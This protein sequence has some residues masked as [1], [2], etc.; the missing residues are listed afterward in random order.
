[1]ENSFIEIF[2]KFGHLSFTEMAKLYKISRFKTYQPG[3]IIVKA[4]DI[5]P[6]S[7]AV[8][9]GVVRT[10]M[11]KTSGEEVTVRI[12]AEKQMTG[13]ANCVLNNEPSFEYL[14]AVEKCSVIE[15]NLVKLK[16]YAKENIRILHFYNDSIAEALNEAVHRI[17]FF[18]SKSPE[19]RYRDL[20]DETPDIIRRVPQK[21]L[22][23][24]IGVT[25]VSLSRIRSRVAKSG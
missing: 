20:L 23:S 1:M 3:E 7:I 19:E 8:L 5:H 4:G 12:V 10:Y 11:I 22:A 6:Y 25:T 14:E 16:D 21:Y 13:A 24:Y 17:S 18:A 2:K 9:K 15:T